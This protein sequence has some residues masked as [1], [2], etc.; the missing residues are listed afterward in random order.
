MNFKS[1]FLAGALFLCSIANAQGNKRGQADEF[2]YQLKSSL[3]KQQIDSLCNSSIKKSENPFEVKSTVLDGFTPNYFFRNLNAEGTQIVVLGD[4]KGFKGNDRHGIYQFDLLSGKATLIRNDLATDAVPLIGL[5]SSDKILS[6]PRYSVDIGPTMMV[7]E[8]LHFNLVRASDEDRANLRLLH[9][10]PSI[11]GTYQSFGKLSGGPNQTTYRILSD[12]NY[13]SEKPTGGLMIS[14]AVI[15]GTGENIHVETSV[16]QQ[17]CKGHLLQLPMISPDGKKIVA[18]EYDPVKQKADT[19]VFDISKGACT[20][21]KIDLG[22]YGGKGSISFDGKQLALSV[23]RLKLRLNSNLS[24][25]KALAE[26]GDRSPTSDIVIVDLESGKSKLL[27]ND[28]NSNF[29]FPTFNSD[30]T[31][32]AFQ[33]KIVNGKMQTS[34]LRLDPSRPTSILPPHS[35]HSNRCEMNGPEMTSKLSPIWTILENLCD[36]LDVPGSVRLDSLTKS[37]CESLIKSLWLKPGFKN[38]LQYENLPLDPFGRES[39]P[40]KALSQGDMLEFCRSN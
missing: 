12:T 36:N 22:L 31:L 25:L 28:P 3:E 11:S 6:F 18:T 17:I 7:E 26:G 38:F 30:G 39:K 8:G 16:P 29:V 21:R 34:V 24:G 20:E 35:V 13:A 27:T 33:Q 23:P 10:E 9:I 4:F 1:T 2:L 32:N 19:K 15:K 40:K 5:H 14:Q 37:Q